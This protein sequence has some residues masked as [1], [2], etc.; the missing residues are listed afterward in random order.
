MQQLSHFKASTQTK[1]LILF[2]ER[3]EYVSYQ[4]GLHGANMLAASSRNRQEFSDPGSK[5]VC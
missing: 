1:V 3:I 4:H 5:G 2:A